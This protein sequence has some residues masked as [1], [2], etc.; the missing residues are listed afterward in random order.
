MDSWT[1]FGAPCKI[2]KDLPRARARGKYSEFACSEARRP[3]NPVTKAI[4]TFRITHRRRPWKGVI[5]R[6]G[7]A[8]S[9]NS[10]QNS[11]KNESVSLS[12]FCFPYHV[13]SIFP[14]LPP[15]PLS[16]SMRIIRALHPN[17]DK[18]CAMLAWTCRE[19]NVTKT[20]RQPGVPGISATP[21]HARG[22]RH[23]KR[24]VE[25]SRAWEQFSVTIAA[26]MAVDKR[27]MPEFNSN[28][29]AITV[30]RETKI[31]TE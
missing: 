3:E 17:S 1:Q 12:L 2:P 15:P 31:L 25:V 5:L 21:R 18:K 22:R 13:S 4:Q 9:G 7:Y 30:R 19:I 10:Y 20:A 14:P 23:A 24:G 11:K 29:E 6:V 8:N 28:T 16:N 26:C 27:I